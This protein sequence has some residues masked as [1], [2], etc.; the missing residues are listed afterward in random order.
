MPDKSKKTTGKLAVKQRPAVY[1]NIPQLLTDLRSMTPHIS[2]Q[3]M[4]LPLRLAAK[5]FVPSSTRSSLYNTYNKLVDYTNNPT[6][7]G[8]MSPEEHELRQRIA[9]TVSYGYPH[10]ARDLTRISEG[11]VNNPGNKDIIPEKEYTQTDDLFRHELVKQYLGINDNPLRVLPSEY[12]P[13][14]GSK[15]A[16]YL[17][18]VPVIRQSLIN[19]LGGNFDTL[20]GIVDSR[21]D[22]LFGTSVKSSRNSGEVDINKEGQLPSSGDDFAT[23][24]QLGT[25]T[26][27]SGKD[28]RGDYIS[29][30]D[31]WDLDPELLEGTGVDLNAVNKPFEIYGRIYRDEIDG[32]TPKMPGGGKIH[33]NKL[34]NNMPDPIKSRSKKMGPVGSMADEQA[35]RAQRIMELSNQWGVPTNQIYSTVQRGAKNIYTGYSPRLSTQFYTVGPNAQ[36]VTDRYENVD[37]GYSGSTY[38]VAGDNLPITAQQKLGPPVSQFNY[39]GQMYHDGSMFIPMYPDNVPP[40]VYDNGGGLSRDKD[41]GSK[42]KP[43]PSV[44]K[45]DFAGGGRSYPIPTKADAIDALR[46][47]GLHGRDDVRAKV[48]KK[49]P[50]LKKG[51]Y[52]VAVPNYDPMMAYGGSMF[53]NGSLFYNCDPHY[54]HGYSGMPPKVY[55]QGGIVPTANSFA[56]SPFPSTFNRQD[57]GPVWK[58]EYPEAA[59]GYRTTGGYN[60][61]VD[62][63]IGGNGYG[64]KSTYRSAASPMAKMGKRMKKA[65]NGDNLYGNL[66]PIRTVQAGMYDPQI[67]SSLQNIPNPL[68]LG[69][70]P[71]NSNPAPTYS[72]QGGMN[73]NLGTAAPIMALAGIVNQTTARQNAAKENARSTRRR[74]Q[75]D[76]YNPYSQGSGATQLY[77]MG[78]SVDPVQQ[79]INTL[80]QHGYDIEMG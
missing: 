76:I 12:K 2:E 54:S 40:K 31:K 57:Y 77:A 14:K 5:T 23:L 1:N 68:S 24:N 7:S 64:G 59:Y 21:K 78:G 43:Y 74:A 38:N 19:S 61:L 79:A 45:G 60:N 10:S 73:F 4:S 8:N 39:G 41:Y 30:Y 66:E 34:T 3:D 20:K 32:T 33:T 9:N 55:D 63:N 27:T 65:A 28:K 49:Y 75:S 17:D 22:H 37:R 47:A 6:P 15:S 42:K 13:T 80:K 48:Y 46:L 58:S 26:L 44:K 70:V 35:V 36:S 72:P 18:F 52:G 56:A 71:S 50:E 67:D 25:Y 51:K 16:N 62:M 29:Y 53:N 11:I 69:E